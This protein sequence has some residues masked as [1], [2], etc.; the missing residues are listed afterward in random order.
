MKLHCD[1]AYHPPVTAP[2]ACRAGRRRVAPMGEPHGTNAR[3]RTSGCV[4]ATLSAV[5][6]FLPDDRAG[7]R[8]G[9]A[10]RRV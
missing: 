10:R 2:A 5:R 4:F 6:G 8:A 3:Y 9:S 1:T 7:D